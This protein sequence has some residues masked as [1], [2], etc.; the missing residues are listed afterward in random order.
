MND[1]EVDKLAEEF[2]Q[3]REAQNGAWPWRGARDVCWYCGGK[4]VWQN[5]YSYE[6]VYGEGEGEGIVTYLI[7]SECGA[8]VTYEHKEGEEE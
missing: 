5:D 7:C 8:R 2:K 3:W 4:L 6:D 1:E